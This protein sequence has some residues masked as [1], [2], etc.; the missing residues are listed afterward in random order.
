MCCSLARGSKLHQLWQHSI[1]PPLLSQ[2]LLCWKHQFYPIK[3]AFTFGTGL[4]F[5]FDQIIP[6]H[7][8]CTIYHQ[9]LFLCFVDEITRRPLNMHTNCFES[10]PVHI[11]IYLKPQVAN[12]FNLSP[13]TAN[14]RALP[15]LWFV[16]LYLCCGWF[17]CCTTAI[18]D[19]LL[20]QF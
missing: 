9:H 14:I 18:F 4:P 17:P 11:C 12:I 7:T 15:S 13:V 3:T 1:W 5:R 6:Y 19:L 10:L 20:W 16:D 8:L 2:L